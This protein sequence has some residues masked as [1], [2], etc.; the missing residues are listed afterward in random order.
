MLSRSAETGSS[1]SLEVVI[2]I[3]ETPEVFIGRA[4]E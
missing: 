1:H 4:R 3:W 2:E